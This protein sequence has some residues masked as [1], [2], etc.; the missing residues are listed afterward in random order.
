MPAYSSLKTFVRSLRTGDTNITLTLAK[1]VAA[2]GVDNI[3]D[4]SSVNPHL[5]VWV[6]GALAKHGMQPEE[7]DH[8]DNEWPEA[9]KEEARDWVVRAVDASQSVA[10]S[11]ELFD[12]EHPANRKDDPGAPEPVRITFRSPRKGVRLSALNYGQIHVDR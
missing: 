11:W 12:G 6:R 8:I 2:E 10:F 7:I 5:S 3:R 1:A 4:P 9:K